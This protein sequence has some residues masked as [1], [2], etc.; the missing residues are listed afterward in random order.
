MSVVSNRVDQNEKMLRNKMEE[1]SER[2]LQMLKAADDQHK[3]FED[4]M[5]RQ[6]EEQ[7]T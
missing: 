2:N 6:Y 4:V 3:K 7:Q 5:N 1:E